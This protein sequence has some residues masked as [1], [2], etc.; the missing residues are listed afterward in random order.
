M[1][2]FF[3]IISVSELYVVH[4]YCVFDCFSSISSP[5][6]RVSYVKCMIIVFLFNIITISVCELHK[7]HDYCIFDYFLFNLITIT[8]SELR[9]MIFMCLTVC[10]IL[11]EFVTFTSVYSSII[12]I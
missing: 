11:F 9:L 6:Q 8:A 3:I 1:T 7:V 12:I 4:D 2:V 10:W 5:F